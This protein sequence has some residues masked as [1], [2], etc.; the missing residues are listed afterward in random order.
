MKLSNDQKRVLR[1]M[2]FYVP[3]YTILYPLLSCLFGK[4]LSWDA[5]LYSFTVSA[6]IGLLSL[7]FIFWG[8]KIPT[9]DENKKEE[10]TG[11]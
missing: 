9:T 6:I 10:K 11:D 5:F 3:A 2:C 4:S 8:M 7:P 1:F